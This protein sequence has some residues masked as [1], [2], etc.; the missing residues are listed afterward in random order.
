MSCT[1]HY[2]LWPERSDPSSE[3]LA[4]MQWLDELDDATQP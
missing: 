1:S 4:F 3:A 2:V